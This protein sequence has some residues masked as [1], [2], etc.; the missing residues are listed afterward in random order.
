MYVMLSKWVPPLE[1]STIGAFVLAGSQFGT[2]IS[3]PLSG[4]LTQIDYDNGWPFAFYVPGAFGVVWFIAW[5]LLVAE[6]PNVHPRISEHE[7]HYIMSV[8]RRE[9]GNT[10][11]SD[12][13]LLKIVSSV[14]F[15]A[16]LVAHTGYNWGFYMLLTELPTYMSTVLH[17]DMKTVIQ[18]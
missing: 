3:Y 13:P 14:H 16:I 18:S 12:I 8:T 17:F 6:E 15:W 11:I 9:P 5:F 2:F 4:L 10:T 7:K 1:R